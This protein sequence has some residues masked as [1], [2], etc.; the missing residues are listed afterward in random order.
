MMM[1]AKQKVVG[2]LLKYHDLNEVLFGVDQVLL[3]F[4]DISDGSN[5]V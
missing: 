1:E 4:P 3:L 5:Y 2:L